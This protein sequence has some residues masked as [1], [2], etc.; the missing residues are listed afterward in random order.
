MPFSVELGR[1]TRLL[2]TQGLDESLGSGKLRV[3][4]VLA[5]NNTAHSA[6]LY[7]EG[8]DSRRAAQLFNE[9][10]QRRNAQ[11][12][13]QAH[14]LL[15]AGAH[16]DVL[17][18]KAV[19][20]SSHKPRTRCSNSLTRG[21]ELAVHLRLPAGSRNPQRRTMHSESASK[22]SCISIR[23][24][25]G[26]SMTVIASLSDAN[27]TEIAVLA[28]AAGVREKRV[29]YEQRWAA[30]A[31]LLRVVEVEPNRRAGAEA[32]TQYAAAL[33]AAAAENADAL[34][35]SCKQFVAC[36]MQHFT[37]CDAALLRR[38]FCTFDTCRPPTGRLKHPLLSACLLAVHK[39]AAAVLAAELQRAFLQ[40]RRGDA[41]A[42]FAAQTH[43]ASDSAGSDSEYSDDE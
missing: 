19:A 40:G 12:V 11:N 37:S 39:A 36:S 23:S 16:G 22:S 43:H 29:Q 21:E 5:Q 6:R 10:V 42:T 28:N 18:H 35:L 27:S 34:S 1:H 25:L 32:V 2:D 38:L 14:W 33:S 31:S 9:A 41:A 4:A 26:A 15:T 17:G 7:A 30:I 8:R 3:M 13:K 24:P 20:T